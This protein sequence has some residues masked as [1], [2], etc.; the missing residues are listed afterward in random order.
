MYE[1]CNYLL[2]LPD[3]G[4]L[5]AELKIQHTRGDHFVMLRKLKMTR[6]GT[7]N[8]E[9]YV[10]L[11]HYYLAYSDRLHAAATEIEHTLDDPLM[12]LCRL[13]MT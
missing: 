5:R 12:M 11:H 1:V 10:V 7:K 13:K 4:L 6:R 8:E 9:V 3:S 2:F